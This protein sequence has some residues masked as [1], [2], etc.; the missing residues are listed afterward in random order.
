MNRGKD[1]FQEVW[2]DETVT[3]CRRQSFLSHFN[4]VTDQED[5]QFLPAS[6]PQPLPLGIAMNSH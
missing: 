2:R 3:E 6:I 4:S 1:V 5:T